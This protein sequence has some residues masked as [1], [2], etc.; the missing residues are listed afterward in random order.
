MARC[1][2]YDSTASLR[3]S[4]PVLEADLG[5]EGKCRRLTATCFSL[6]L[7]PSLHDAEQSAAPK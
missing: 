4:P 3:D 6:P 7:H 2:P 1:A 5:K